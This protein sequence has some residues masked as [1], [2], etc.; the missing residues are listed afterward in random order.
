MTFVVIIVG[1]I[2]SY[3]VARSISKTI[4]DLSS[5]INV[6]SKGDFTVKIP[7]HLLKIKN[8]IGSMAEDI[9]KLAHSLGEMLKN[10]SGKSTQLD[11][12]AHVVRNSSEQSNYSMD[13]IELAINEIAKGSQTQAQ[14]TQEVTQHVVHI[15]EM[16]ENMSTQ[17]FALKESANHME[18][19]NEE[20]DEMM[21]ELGKI[22]KQVQEAITVISEQTQQTNQS[23]DQIQSAIDMITAITEQT[24]L[25]S[26][27]AS[28]EAARAGEQGKGFAVVADEIRKLA[29]QS[30]QSAKQIE[31]IIAELHHVSNTAV[32]SMEETKEII[33]S[34]NQKIEQTQ[35]IFITVKSEI[36]NV[37]L[38]I[39]MLLQNIAD[40]SQ[41]KLGVVE[42][43]EGLLALSEE[44]AS[45][46]QETSATTQ[47]V[48][49]SIQ[50]IVASANELQEMSMQLTE[51]MNVF[52]I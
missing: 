13:Q 40:I 7:E 45:S 8:E 34:Q 11:D 47:D 2:A 1:C 14:E 9:G 41:S 30:G 29:E 32:A 19:A 17:T 44:Y 16:I 21:N 39:E 49:S 26:L 6:I 18:K 23:V 48:A 42:G 4:T 43:I 3:I 15:G 5:I 50:V 25:L 36:Q 12:L 37:I 20:Q 46:T 31:Q 27:N 28:I 35:K 38:N 22:N 24:N 51:I 52:K 33:E 10:V